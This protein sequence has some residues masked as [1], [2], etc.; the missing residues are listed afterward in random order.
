[1]KINLKMRS[2][3]Y[4][5]LLISLSIIMIALFGLVSCF[6]SADRNY[7][8]IVKANIKCPANLKLE[9]SPWGEDG[10]IAACKIVE[11]PVVAAR[12]GR[13]V[14]TGQNANGSPTGDWLWLDK[15]GKIVSKESK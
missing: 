6:P 13:V 1:M 4:R 14:M 11:G 7:D 5:N 8:A 15:D 9:I 12:Y 3:N 10:L 2:N